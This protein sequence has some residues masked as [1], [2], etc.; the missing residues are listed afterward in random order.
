MSTQNEVPVTPEPSHTDAA[1]AL[2]GDV[3]AMRERIPNFVIPDSKGASRKLVSAATVPPQFIELTAV[4]VK[5]SDKL[6]RGGGADPAKLRNLMSFAD[7][8]EPV[9]D[10]LEALAHFIRHSVITARNTAGSDA[11][12]TYALAQRLAKRP[13][14][15]DLAPHVED[16]RRALGNRVRKA[17]AK[18][19]PAPAPAQPSPVTASSPETPSK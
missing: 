4:A 10:E 1:Q 17:K 5:N 12:T 2:V 15:A 13:E 3:R 8:Y 19:A 11:L 9:A 6:T 7:A 18:P 16:M 14:S